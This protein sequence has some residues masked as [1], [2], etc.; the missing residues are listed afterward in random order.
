MFVVNIGNVSNDVILGDKFGD[1]F[2]PTPK[3]LVA[4]HLGV[5]TER[6]TKRVPVG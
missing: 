3:S 2:E 4:L 6:S 5:N 1:K